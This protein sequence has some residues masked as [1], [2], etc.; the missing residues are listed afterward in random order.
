M[1]PATGAVDLIK[2]SGLGVTLGGRR[3]LSDIDLSLSAG[4][5]VTLIGPNGAG[6]TT[7]VRTLLGLESPTVGRMMRKEGLRI[8]YMPQ[9]VAVDP[10]LPLNVARFLRLGARR[11]GAVRA[12]GERLGL[13]GLLD[14][15][16]QGLSGGE[17]QR[18]LLA[19][20]L[21]RDPELLV[22]D[23]PA[24][25]VD[26]GLQSG[27]Y[28][29]IREIRDELG[30][31]VLMVSHDLHLV[32]AATDRVVCLNGHICCTGLPEAVSRDPAYQRLF[33]VADTRGL[34]VYAHVHD[35]THGAVSGESD[36]GGHRHA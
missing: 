30:C 7:L 24:Q 32:M 22:L 10:I 16:I 26:V 19:R 27:F 3:I 29:L 34:A 9:R 35:H 12:A 33:G 23:E 31:G 2:A 18:V 17:M 8:G 11:R 1:T 20:A 5:I 14:S 28:T 25:G 6:K 21:L 13:V 4:E 36:E 15:P